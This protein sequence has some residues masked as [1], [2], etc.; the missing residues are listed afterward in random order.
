MA[1]LNAYDETVQD[2]ITIHKPKSNKNYSFKRMESFK[3]SE[4]EK[5]LIFEATYPKKQYDVLTQILIM[6]AQTGI[7]KISVEELAKKANCGRTTVKEVARKLKNGTQIL[8]ARLKSRKKNN[9]HYIFVDK[10][11]ENFKAILKEVFMLD[12]SE[13]ILY[14]QHNDHN[15]DQLKS[16]E[17]VDTSSLNKEKIGYKGF[18]GF[19]SLKQA[20]NN[21]NIYIGE[22]EKMAISEEIENEKS[23]SPEEQRKQLEEYSTNQYQLAFYDFIQLMTQY[24]KL[25]SDNAYKLSLRIGSDCTI[26][27]FMKAKNVL[28]RLVM[29][30]DSGLQVDN[31]VATFTGALKN[32]LSYPEIPKKEVASIPEP[33]KC[34]FYNWLDNKPVQKDTVKPIETPSNNQTATAVTPKIDYYEAK[35]KE[36]AAKLGM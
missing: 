23:E 36:I 13:I 14:D 35:R 25:V 30:I 5:G 20:I 7:S 10:L 28:Q 32:K 21:N 26:E 11:H 2:F 33:P 4:K 16:A 24:P 18:K 3:A 22:S 17:N 6:V 15:S 27:R 12:E 8:V 9:G 29:D 34:A 1:I 19:N 31:I